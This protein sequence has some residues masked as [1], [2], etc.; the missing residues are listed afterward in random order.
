MRPLRFAQSPVPQ[1][2]ERHDRQYLPIQIGI[3]P[4]LNPPP[5][6]IYPCWRVN[7]SRTGKLNSEAGASALCKD[8][9]PRVRVLRK[10][11]TQGTIIM[12]TGGRPA[13][14]S[15]GSSRVNASG[16]VPPVAARH[17]ARLVRAFGATP[18]RRVGG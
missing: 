17:P 15:A 11:G 5:R 10:R 8:Y 6:G 18:H 12:L 13:R 2:G 3:Y 16:L 14:L 4:S 9:A 7:E 1:E